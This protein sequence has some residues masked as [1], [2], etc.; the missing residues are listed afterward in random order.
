MADLSARR[1]W[2]RDI[3]ERMVLK[4]HYSADDRPVKPVEQAAVLN[5]IDRYAGESGWYF[6]Q[7][8]ALAE[9]SHLSVRQTKRVLEVLKRLGYVDRQPFGHGRGDHCRW[10]VIHQELARCSGLPL[11]DSVPTARDQVPKRPDSVPTWPDQVPDLSDQVPIWAP[12]ELLNSNERPRTSSSSSLVSA[13]EGEEVEGVGSKWNSVA[14]AEQPASAVP[15]SWDE[16]I[17]RLRDTGLRATDY[18]VSEAR[19]RRITP[20]V[21]LR[22]VEV[23]LEHRRGWPGRDGQPNPGVITFWVRQARIGDDPADLRLWP[24]ISSAY[25]RELTQAREQAKLDRDSRATAI[26]RRGRAAGRSDEQ[27][28][29]ELQAAGLQ[30][31]R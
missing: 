8:P 25:R 26:I 18:V 10:R 7:V 14:I 9:E 12:Q 5:V 22:V 24:S 15:H 30:W 23:Y 2:Q 29:A 4:K 27:I 21:L 17:A 6:R 20:E 19:C 28:H 11:W 13:S 1:K 3:L 16:A 31:P